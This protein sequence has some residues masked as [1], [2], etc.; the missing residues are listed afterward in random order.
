[1]MNMSQ[2][3][4]RVDLCA[5]ILKLPSQSVD[6]NSC[7][8]AVEEPLHYPR[9]YRC[10]RLPVLVVT[11]LSQGASL[12]LLVKDGSI[13]RKQSL[14]LTI[15]EVRKTVN[16]SEDARF[17]PRLVSSRLWCAPYLCAVCNGLCRRPVICNC[18]IA[19]RMQTGLETSSAAVAEDR[20]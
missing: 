20:S 17:V 10:A 12:A 3:A 19:R 5:L 15:F 11:K 7:P 13:S 14:F 8:L 16:A 4:S 6:K 1:M 18:D 2:A 9:A